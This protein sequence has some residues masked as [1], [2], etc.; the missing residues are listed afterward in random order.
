MRLVAG[1][2]AIV[3]LGCAPTHELHVYRDL[4]R[5]P[6]RGPGCDVVILDELDEV[7]A[8][9]RMIGD[10][11][12]ARFPSSDPSPAYHAI[13]KSACEIGASLVRVRIVAPGESF[14]AEL[15]RCDPWPAGVV[16][17]PSHEKTQERED[18]RA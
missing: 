12:D 8:E 6:S 16:D 11:L 14:R 9:C 1:I 7:P 5:L 18:H 2:L 13:Q 10:V 4:P 3:L 15:Y 17:E